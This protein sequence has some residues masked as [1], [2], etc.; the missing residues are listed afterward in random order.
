M[1]DQDGSRVVLG[2]V[3]FFLSRRGDTRGSGDWSS[4]VCSSDLKF[5]LQGREIISD[6]GSARFLNVEQKF[7]GRYLPENK[8]FAK[9]TRSEERRVGKEGRFRGSPY[10]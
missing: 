8:S 9:Q 10:P 5:L 1:W 7:G 6:Y 3:F 2:L 4:D